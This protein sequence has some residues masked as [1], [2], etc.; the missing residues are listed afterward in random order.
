MGDNNIVKRLRFVSVLFLASLARRFQIGRSKG[1]PMA[2]SSK[3]DD[4]LLTFGCPQCGRALIKKGRW[5]KSVARFKCVGCQLE[6]Q[7]TYGD[8]LKL[9]AKHARLAR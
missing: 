3:L 8:K 5:F 4:V 2:L 9:F 7:I 6:T 1:A